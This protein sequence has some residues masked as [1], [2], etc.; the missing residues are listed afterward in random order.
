MIP[1]KV[2]LDN[3]YNLFISILIGTIT[4][5]RFFFKKL[6][7]GLDIFHTLCYCFTKFSNKMSPHVMKIPF[8]V[9]G[10]NILLFSCAVK[11]LALYIF[12]IFEVISYRFMT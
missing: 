10:L 6:D 11:P 5:H 12:D 8:I 2:Q 9:G 4:K 3:A 7:N 1:M